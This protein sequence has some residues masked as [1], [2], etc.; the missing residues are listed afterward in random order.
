MEAAPL[1]WAE[2]LDLKS[3]D[4]FLISLST[5]TGYEP[6]DGAIGRIH[7]VIREFRAAASTAREESEG[8]DAR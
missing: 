5:A 7:E 6:M 4:N 8:G 3:L 1:A 2:E